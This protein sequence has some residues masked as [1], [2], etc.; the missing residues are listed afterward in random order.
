MQTLLGEQ[1]E[2]SSHDSTLPYQ[3]VRC[4]FLSTTCGDG[5]VDPGEECDDG[6]RN[7]A[8]PNALCRPGCSA[9]RCG[10]GTI[11]LAELCD[12]GNRLNG[13]GCDRYCKTEGGATQVASDT[14]DPLQNSQYPLGSNTAFPQFQNTQQ[15]G[16]PQYPNFQQLP[17]QLPLAQ[18]RPIVQQQGPVGDTGPAAVAIVGAGA[19]GGLSWIR[20]RRK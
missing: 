4:R 19:A 3:C 20:R 15:Y 2:N 5:N 7:S 14:T 8:A 17:Y 10:D 13:D 11:D 6:R 9:A 1:C 18:L 16:F 12:D